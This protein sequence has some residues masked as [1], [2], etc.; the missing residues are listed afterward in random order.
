MDARALDLLDAALTRPP[1]EREA[2]LRE[3][4]ADDPALMADALALLRA[5]GDSAGLLE[6]PRMPERIG[7]WHLI[8]PLGAGGMGEVYLAERRDGAYEQRAALKL[9]ARGW[10]GPEALARFHAERAF[11]ARLEHPNIA[12]VIDGGTAGDGRPYV[13]M[14]YIDGAPIDRWCGA[15]QW[16]IRQRIEL[17]RQVLAAVDA[18]HRALILH[19]DLKPANILVTDEGQAKL[20]DFGIAKR[21]DAEAGLTATGLAPLTP[22][23]ASPEQ[24]AG[25]PLTTA[26]DVYALGLVLHLL[27]TGRLP[28]EAGL[29]SPAE[30][31]AALRTAVPSRPSATLDPTALALSEREAALWRRHLEG[32]L[33]RVLLKAL[34]V[35]VER[36]YASAA[37]FGA[38][39]E[40]WLQYRPVAA[41]QGDRGYRLRLFLR[42]N[43]LPVVAA[44]AAVLALAVGLGVAAQQALLAR[45]EAARAASANEF[46]L[47]LIADADPVASG[48]E[49]S[50]KE[51][52]DQAVARIPEYFADQPEGEADVR[53]GIGRAYTNLMQ[54]EPAAAQFERALALREP[55]TAGHA[56]VLQGQALLDW[57]RGRTDRAE[58]RY[59]EAL[60]IYAADPALRRQAG[61]VRNDLA[62]LLSDVGRY[63]EAVEQARAAVADARALELE[64]GALG[65]RL[66]NLGSAL[67]GAGRLDEADTVYHEAITALEQALPERTVALAV[68]LN[69]YALVHRDAGRTREALALF[70]RAI[71]VRESAFGRDHADLAGPLTNAA[72]MRLALG[73]SA[74]AQRDIGRALTLAEK[75]YAPDY[76]GRGHVA[77]AAAEIAAA[78]GDQATARRQAE[79]ALAV[80]ERADA[81]D[82]AWI[83]RARA[84]T[85]AR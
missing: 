7:P 78:G 60:T 64:A 48:R 47:R 84:I 8:E 63:P 40:R 14:E 72:R 44:S 36:R 4:A 9:T 23:Y 16:T 70:E 62:A 55:G 71:A 46:L 31:E 27:L 30:I 53:L 50:L 76:I 51:A 65:A 34:A 41:R 6:G 32:D 13:V 61:A 17:F 43:R 42:R 73:D 35:D 67:Q 39:L 79:A 49:P 20:L 75:A 66:E 19:R 21:L 85:G 69:N 37:D 45:A 29:R 25:K 54:L 74:G 24:L 26:S 10:A 3:T 77:L 33:D 52:L 82:P 57:T 81:A 56:D 58:R 22:Q 11:L 18:A 38:D 83:A 59:R 28:H 68:A 5:H 80:F 12:R 15:R 2:F 1:P